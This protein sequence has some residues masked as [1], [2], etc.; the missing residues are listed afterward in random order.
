MYF[1]IVQQIYNSKLRKTA[2]YGKVK[3]I[4]FF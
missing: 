2:V 1:D 4:A 3:S